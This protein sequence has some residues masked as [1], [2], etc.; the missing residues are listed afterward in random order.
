[1]L[2]IPLSVIQ[3]GLPTLK[4]TVVYRQLLFTVSPCNTSITGNDF[5]RHSDCSAVFILW[6][7]KIWD[8]CHFTLPFMYGYYLY[9]SRVYLYNALYFGDA[10]LPKSKSLS[11]RALQSVLHCPTLFLCEASALVCLH[12]N[13][14]ACSLSALLE[15]SAAYFR[16]FYLFASLFLSSSVLKEG[17]HFRSRVMGP[18]FVEMFFFGPVL[19]PP[20]RLTFDL[21]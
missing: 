10:W 7:G 3:S 16:S 19:L 1:M 2:L 21:S 5:S 6:H 13:V 9:V 15:V 12:R 4:S 18:W 11:W 8:Q 14:S 20:S 17:I